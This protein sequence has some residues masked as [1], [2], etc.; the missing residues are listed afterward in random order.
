M[1]RFYIYSGFLADSYL[2]ELRLKNREFRLLIFCFIVG[3]RCA[4]AQ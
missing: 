1:L 4:H 2:F 3:F